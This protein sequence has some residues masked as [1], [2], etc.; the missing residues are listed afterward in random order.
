MASHP[1]FS[2]LVSD[3]NNIG[4]RLLGFNVD[5]IDEAQF[6]KFANDEMG[7]FC[8]AYEEICI[9]GYFS[10]GFAIEL[11]TALSGLKKKVRIITAVHNIKRPNDKKNL[12]SLRK[13]QDIGAEIRVN[14]RTHFR[15]FLLKGK[16]K[17]LLILGS[18]DFNKEGMNMERRDAGIKT[19]HPD[20][21]QSAYDYFMS[22]WE[23][24]HDCTP[25]DEMYPDGRKK[26]KAP[27][28]LPVPT[29]TPSI[30]LPAVLAQGLRDDS[31]NVFRSSKKSKNEYFVAGTGL[32]SGQIV[33]VYLNTVAENG[34]L[35]RIQ[36]NPDGTWAGLVK[37][38]SGLKKGDH[39]LWMK[40]IGTGQTEMSKIEL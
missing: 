33:E 17:G 5:F 18:F 23:D 11:V 30:T 31:N 3:S 27:V 14:L 21:V 2:K 28:K 29:S 4:K 25:L 16:T 26:K 20:L 22:V 40:D 38:P 24:E 8:Q 15:M 7:S 39:Y 35:K 9:S 1:K 6:K 12:A 13:I 37:L 32:V 10:D 34:L 36:V 19:T